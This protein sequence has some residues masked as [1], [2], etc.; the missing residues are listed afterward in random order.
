MSIYSGITEL[1]AALTP[2][3]YDVYD[4]VPSQQIEPPCFVIEA[5]EPFLTPGDSFDMTEWKANLV[6]WVLVPLTDEYDAN[7]YAFQKALEQLLAKLRGGA[8]GVDSIGR[9]TD[10]TAGEW[11]AWGAGVQVSSFININP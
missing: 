8:W 5:A 3:G 1:V 6:V 10:K 11:L 9:P 2:T 7:V 4:H